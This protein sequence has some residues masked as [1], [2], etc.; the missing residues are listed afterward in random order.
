MKV[1]IAASILSANLLKL[2]EEIEAVQKAGVDMLHLDIMDGHFVPNLS[3][4]AEA[5]RAIKSIA[6]VPLGVHLMIDNP[7]LYLEEF[8][9][10]GA[11]TVT[12]HVE[13]CV[14]LHRVV[15]QI[16]GL[17]IKAGVALNPATPVESIQYLI[18]ELDAVLV[19]SVDPGFGG[20]EFIPQMLQKISRARRL[21]GDG[22]DI[23]VDGGI[24]REN[25]R[26]I[27]QAGASIL[28]VGTGIFT[29]SDYAETIKTLRGNTT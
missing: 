29:S 12:V 18:G 4:G 1:L 22:V 3:Y 9:S 13:A 24:K 6:S 21:L 14:H 27:V 25:I 7:G 5:V 19:M 20:Q 10:A 15:R 23:M 17:G 28:V 2:G 16:K 8:A 26:Q 11:T